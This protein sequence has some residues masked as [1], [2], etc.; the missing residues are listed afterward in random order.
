MSNKL[1][2]LVAIGAGIVA[3]VAFVVIAY[4]AIQ[5][6][7]SKTQTEN[8]E[9]VDIMTDE[10]GTSSQET[11]KPIWKQEHSRNFEED[12]LTIRI[13]KTEFTATE[14]DIASLQASQI[15][16]H[17]EPVPF[18]IT[19]RVTNHFDEQYV[20]YDQQMEVSGL[21]WTDVTFYGLEDS[22]PAYITITENGKTVF[23]DMVSG[24]GI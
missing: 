23:V 9:V 22:H 19:I 15:A 2:L 17:Y 13:S 20:T 24:R 4:P 16:E 8:L 14:V 6:P 7:L 11:F 10:M 18:T 1:A 21:D 12:S 5:A 3:I